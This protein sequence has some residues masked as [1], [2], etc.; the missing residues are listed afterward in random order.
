MCPWGD[1]TTK[2]KRGE[3]ALSTLVHRHLHSIIKAQIKEL[4]KG[5]GDLGKSTWSWLCQSVTLA[6]SHCPSG[7]Q[8]P[9][10]SRSKRSPFSQV[11]NKPPSWALNP[12]SSPSLG[13]LSI[14]YDL[15]QY[16]VFLSPKSL[17]SLSQL[18]L[19]IKGWEHQVSLSV[20]KPSKQ[21]GLF[22][23]LTLLGIAHSA[24]SRKSQPFHLL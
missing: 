7:T 4:R 16:Q 18:V 10:V 6:L 19:P 17:S 8:F 2:E 14:S 11:K 24:S 12:N 23:S 1:I 3:K 22:D 9:L 15:S 5:E 21:D 20:R 13:M